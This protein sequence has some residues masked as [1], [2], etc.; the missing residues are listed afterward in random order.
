MPRPRVE[1]WPVARSSSTSTVPAAAAIASTAAADRGARPRL[2]WMTTP[3]ALS[4][5]VSVVDRGGSAASVASTT[6]SGPMPPART[7]S[8]AS[9][10]AARTDVAAQPRDRLCH[11]GFREDRI[12]ARHEATRVRR[13]AAAA[14]ALLSVAEADGNRTRPA[15]VLG[16]TGFEDREGHQAPVRLRERG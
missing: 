3:V 6:S 15:E 5:G 12:G 2:V 10:T 14:Y 8:W 16:C 13:A 9:C 4:T 1:R 7:C 11:S